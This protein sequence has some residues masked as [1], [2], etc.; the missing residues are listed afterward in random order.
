MSTASTTSTTS[1]ASTINIEQ[2]GNTITISGDMT[3]DCKQ[4]HRECAG[5][6]HGMF[7]D[8]VKLIPK[9]G[10]KRTSAQIRG[11]YRWGTNAEYYENDNIWGYL[12]YNPKNHSNYI[13]SPCDGENRDNSYH[14]L[15]NGVAYFESEGFDVYIIPCSN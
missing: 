9:L 13:F 5:R 12:C 3:N 4:M 7:G 15:R 1:T 10:D 11:L 14:R 2:D 8:M 6:F